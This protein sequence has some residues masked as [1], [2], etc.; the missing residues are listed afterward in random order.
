MHRS[1]MHKSCIVKGKSGLAISNMAHSTMAFYPYVHWPQIPKFC[2][3]IVLLLETHCSRQR[4][5]ATNILHTWVRGYVKRF[6][7]ANLKLCRLH[8]D[9]VVVLCLVMLI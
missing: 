2:I 9:F 5:C 4:T 6:N 1:P 3:Q 8:C 7:F